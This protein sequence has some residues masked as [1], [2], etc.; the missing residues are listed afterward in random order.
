MPSSGTNKSDTV[1]GYPVS[2]YNAD[3][4]QLTKQLATTKDLNDRLEAMDSAYSFTT[5]SEVA[6]PSD[7]VDRYNDAA[8]TYNSMADSLSKK[9]GMAIDGSGSRLSDPDNIELP[10]KR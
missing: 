9:Y 6:E 5:Q 4:D 8:D 10:P 1:N 2:E 3:V 7:I